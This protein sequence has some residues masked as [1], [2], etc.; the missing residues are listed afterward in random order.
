MFFIGPPG[1]GKTECA[2][3]LARYLM[4]REEALLRFD[5]SEY[6]ERS[7]ISTL[8]GSDKG[9]VD[10]EKG[11]YLTEP[12]RQNPHRVILFDEIEKAHPSVF[13]IFLQILDNGEIHDKRGC[14]V[15]F[16]HAMCIFTS[17]VGCDRD[18]DLFDCSR[19]RIVSRLGEFFRP[20]FLDRVEAFVPFRSLDASARK[21]IAILQLQRL[22]EQMGQTHHIDL[23]WTNDV[24][25]LA[26]EP[27]DGE[28]GARH[29]LR[30]IQSEVK[31]VLVDALF[32][33]RQDRNVV[34]R[35]A[36]VVN[37]TGQ[38]AAHNGDR[39]QLS[40]QDDEAS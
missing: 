12:V 38:L 11:G 5:M 34:R 27:P 2:K 18:T 26:C 10:S 33:V 4:G 24:P 19:S 28:S 3:L 21:S 31:P 15:S 39:L 1:T 36:L 37:D 17:N 32:G 6:H 7:S 29:I 22:Q 30:W 9:L 35:I 13:N 16:R 23:E 25:V 20:E 40:Q 14:L 8:L